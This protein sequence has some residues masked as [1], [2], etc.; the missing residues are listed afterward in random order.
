MK[1]VTASLLGALL[2]TMGV[3]AARAQE[4]QPA[5]PGA[6]LPLTLSEAIERALTGSPALGQA[7]ALGRAAEADA[8]AARAARLPQLALSA[9]YTRNSNVP[10][11]TLNLP[12]GPPRTIFPN[13]PDNY[14]TRLA[15]S[16]PIDL[17]GRLGA[18][19]T[20]AAD[21]EKAAAGDVEGT[22]AQIVLETT[23]A[24]WSL[25]TSRERER[26][27][28]E[29]LTSYDAH[30]KDARNRQQIGMA[31]SNEVL[32]V[33]VD[34]DEAELS[35][36]RASSAAELAD[37]TLSRLLGLA[38]GVRVEPVDRL[39]QS[40]PPPEDLEQLVRSA[41]NARPER[42]ALASRLLAAEARV[43]AERANRLPQLAAG[44][45]YDYS[46]PNTKILPPE[47]RWND[48][49]DVSV[50][51]SLSLFDSGRISAAVARAEARAEAARRQLEDLDRAIRLQVT[52]ALLDLST[53]QATVGVTERSLVSA[54]E[55]RRVA[56]DRYREGLIPSAELLDAEVALLRAGVDRA[57]A[58][59]Q[60]RLAAASL[61]R[62]VGR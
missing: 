55:N 1:R 39:E 3:A 49:W 12:G 20:A 19:S 41:V 48:T 54:Q 37:A 38:P 15:A 18:L 8:R 13:I 35:R 24:Y 21:E 60:T 56:A 45:G 23:S 30:L 40:S 11:L 36:L 34:R 44:A 58:L 14:R 5:S 10:E 51:L 33:Q 25:V 42:M 32:A 4:S 47:A 57:E 53:A 46:N 52:R 16:V 28:S 17:S 43:R 27:L 22:A 26:V 59:A 50:N 9:S 6:F 62:A 61:N 2:T 7:R 31:A 29:A